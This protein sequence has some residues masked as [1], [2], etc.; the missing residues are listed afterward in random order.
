MNADGNAR[1]G[2][3]GGNEHGTDDYDDE[4]EHEHEHGST[5]TRTST[6]TD[7]SARTII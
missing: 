6:S 7:T 1:L 3:A 5:S 4:D 2:Q